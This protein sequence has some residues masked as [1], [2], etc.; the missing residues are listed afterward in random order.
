[1]HF[2]LLLA[3]IVS[4]DPL[5]SQVKTMH[6]LAYSNCPTS[7][8]GTALWGKPGHSTQLNTY[9]FT[10]SGLISW[11]SNY[12]IGKRLFLRERAESK[13]KWIGFT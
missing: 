2:L 7:V 4:D 3:V 5:H 9:F 6:V 12:V 11:Q 13:A 8:D 10:A 1:M